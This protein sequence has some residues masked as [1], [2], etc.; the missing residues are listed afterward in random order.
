[1]RSCV[2]HFECLLLAS[3]LVFP[4]CGGRKEVTRAPST[5]AKASWGR[6]RSFDSEPGYSV[7]KDLDH[8]GMVDV[9]LVYAKEDDPKSLIRSRWDLNHDGKPDEW[10]YYGPDGEVVQEEMDLDWD[11]VVDSINYYEDGQL[12]RREAS[13]NFEGRMTVR[14]EFEHGQL[15]LIAQDTDDDGKLDTWEFYENGQLVRIGKDT[16]KDGQEDLFTEPTQDYKKQADAAARRLAEAIQALAGGPERSPEGGDGQQ[17]G[18]TPDGGKA[19]P[20]TPRAGPDA[21]EPAAGTAPATP[22]APGSEG[23][24]EPAGGQPSSAGGAE[25]A[26]DQ[27][28]TH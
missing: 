24:G 22:A 14:K 16:N 3:S 21:D 11:G 20:S 27:P 8:D 23:A 19:Q 1:M 4:A 18:A 28:G 9:T 6:Y 12:V 25:S 5:P 17:G 7:D 2:R 15:T 26:P 10:V 13:T